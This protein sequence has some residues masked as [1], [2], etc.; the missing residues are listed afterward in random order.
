MGAND[1]CTPTAAQT[2]PLDAFTTSFRTALANYFTRDTDAFV[3]VS[4]LPNLKQLYDVLSPISSAR[5]TWTTFGICQSM[6][7][8]SVSPDQR[9]LV[10]NQETAFNNALATVCA[11]FRRCRWDNLAT[12]NVQFTR[13]DVSTLDYFHPSVAGQAKLA[14]TAWAAG[15]WPAS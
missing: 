1:L 11:E 15:Y 8:A 12:Y 9:Q 2:T 6:L 10:V 3:F 14:A 13:S 7:G 4:S 5:S